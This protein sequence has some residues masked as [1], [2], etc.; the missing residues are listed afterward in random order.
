MIATVVNYVGPFVWL[1]IAFSIVLLSISRGIMC[2]PAALLSTDTNTPDVN[3]STSR[4]G[5]SLLN[6]HSGESPEYSFVDLLVGGG[7]AVV[8]GALTPSSSSSIGW[9][10]YVLFPW[11]PLHA[12]SGE[13]IPTIIMFLR[14][15]VLG[16]A[17]CAAISATWFIQAVYNSEHIPLSASTDFTYRRGKGR[18]SAHPYDVHDSFFIAHRPSFGSGSSS[19]SA[20]SSASSPPSNA[21]GAA[22]TSGSSSSNNGAVG[23]GSG[24]S[25]GSNAGGGSGTGN[26]GNTI[27][28]NG[29]GVSMGSSGLANAIRLSP[30]SSPA[31][32]ALA[33]MIAALRHSNP[34]VSLHAHFDLYML[35]TSSAQGRALI[36]N[37]EKGENW[38]LIFETLI[39]AID[40]ASV[41][42][43][44]RC[45]LGDENATYVSG[46]PLYRLQR[47][48]VD[49]FKVLL[50]RHSD[51]KKTTASAVRDIRGNAKQTAQAIAS[52]LMIG[53]ST[54]EQQVLGAR[55]LFAHGVP[56]LSPVPIG[57]YLT[58]LTWGI[59]A[60][61]RLVASSRTQDRLGI[62][63]GPDSLSIPVAL[64]S[65][66]SLFAMLDLALS[67]DLSSVAGVATGRVGVTTTGLPSASQDWL[68]S[69]GLNR[70]QLVVQTNA[71]TPLRP[72]SV[73]R[74]A[75]TTMTGASSVQPQ[76]P[77]RSTHASF[78]DATLSTPLFSR[79]TIMTSA[80]PIPLSAQKTTR[81]A[82]G[83]SMSPATTSNMMVGGG[84]LTSSALS[85]PLGVAAAPLFDKSV[86]GHHIAE[87]HIMHLAQCVSES[88]YLIVTTYY[89]ELPRFQFSPAHAAL[90][91][92]F[93]SF[94]G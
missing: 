72:G 14:Y 59:R 89:Q 21:S 20:A 78:S 33:P 93:T 58:Q 88:I 85:T 68:A 6:Q 64:E 4:T 70:Q 86:Y 53:S 38:H 67:G 37:E 5:A 71:A 27:D 17:I 23:G 16:G 62:V 90:L 30:T 46:S 54:A 32:I 55:V 73:S 47:S 60:L 91:R 1:M 43:H 79:P 69:R 7:H 48:T 25:A 50:G 83:S 80:T 26:G 18:Q 29:R 31:R 34:F 13:L 8:C 40:S 87:P 75:A 81:S 56:G 84:H 15:T 2:S 3:G 41:Q 65:L 9:L 61:A 51:K 11:V 12:T 28:N 44:T 77:A 35:A 49:L 10:S 52:L 45:M 76:T 66:L 82:S 94:S 63:T 24:S 22:M 39:G 74:M 42:I 36:Y 19:S 92:R 57:C